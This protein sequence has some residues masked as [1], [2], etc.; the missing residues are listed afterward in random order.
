M[1]T[2]DCLAPLVFERTKQLDSF[3]FPV[4]GTGYAIVKGSG[5]TFTGVNKWLPGTIAHAVIPCR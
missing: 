1:A 2:Y 4:S 3:Y 5:Y